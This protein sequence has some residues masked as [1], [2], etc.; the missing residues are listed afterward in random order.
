MRKLALT[1]FLLFILAVPASAS[2]IVAPPVPDDVEDLIPS[3]DSDI[4]DG[5]ITIVKRAV[6]QTQP[7]VASG[8]KSVGQI[9]AIILVLSVI[10]NMDGKSKAVADLGC[11]LAIAYLL[12]EKSSSLL[13][14]SAQTI[15]DI[16]QYGKL[17]LPALTAALAAQGGSISAAGLYGATCLFDALLSSVISTALMPMVYIF[18]VHAIM[19]AVTGDD[20][21]AKARNFIKWAVTWC[22]KLVLYV[23]T[24]YIT[25]SG[26][27]SGGADQ[28]AIK[29]T[30]LTISGMIPVVGGILS[31]A[32]ETILVS[33]RI[34]KNSIGLYGLWGIIAITI[35][36]ILEVGI[37]YL[38][39]KL[40]FILASVFA[41]KT[42]TTLL[43]DLSSAMGLL[44]GM[45]GS[46]CLLQMISIVCF[47]KGM[48]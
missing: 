48:A 13:E 1:I 14:R 35:L 21:L 38:S 33:A 11:V 32:S 6:A 41:P 9:T 23:F 4:G 16:S 28:T 7:Q 29:A 10:R 8:I 30:K 19:N 43:E 26:I 45:I 15:L 31:D 44:M 5:L 17:L 34:V 22:L 47:L 24:G 37:V 12:L 42:I 3:E 27:I 2:G 39:M 36:P 20:L 18:L 40:S 46:V 25:I